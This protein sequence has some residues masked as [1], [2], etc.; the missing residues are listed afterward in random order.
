[1]IVASA[2]AHREHLPDQSPVEVRQNIKYHVGQIWVSHP[3]LVS[4]MGPRQR[5]PAKW[6]LAFRP[7]TAAQRTAMVT[8]SGVGVPPTAS[9]TGTALPGTVFAGICTLTCPSPATLPGA[10]PA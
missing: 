10:A 8:P 4:A 7:A 6:A 5:T 3:R 1:M 2:G 9:R